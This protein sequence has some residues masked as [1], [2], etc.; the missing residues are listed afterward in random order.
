MPFVLWCK[1]NI[2]SHQ[3][4]REGSGQEETG[5]DGDSQVSVSTT[6]I[7]LIINASLL[8]RSKFKA[9]VENVKSSLQSLSAQELLSLLDSQDYV[10]AVSA[11]DKYHGQVFSEEQLELLLDRSDL[12]WENNKTEAKPAPASNGIKGVFQVVDVD[13]KK[14]DLGSVKEQV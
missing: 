12:A 14:K 9:G 2:F 1:I 7:C 11:S 10:G 4:R 13:D 3:D 8:T 6:N 5:E